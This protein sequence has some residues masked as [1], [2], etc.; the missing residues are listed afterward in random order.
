MGG[1]GR[2]AL[3]FMIHWWGWILI[4][5]GLVLALL[6]VLALTGWWLFR[7][8]LRLLDDVSGLAEKAEILDIDDVELPKQTIA[9][10]ADLREIRAREDARLSHRAKRR[11]ERHRRRMQRARR[12][13]SADASRQ[14]W[15]AD[16][17]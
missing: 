14:Q 16:W 9:V 11:D 2:R 15:P 13:T 17:Y 3:R 4:W 10:L 6:V 8:A 5:A 12:I 1:G 7:K